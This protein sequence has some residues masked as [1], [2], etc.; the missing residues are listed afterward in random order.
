M[1]PLLGDAFLLVLEET[2]SCYIFCGKNLFVAEY[3]DYRE[4][5]VFFSRV[6]TAPLTRQKQ[7]CHVNLSVLS[8]I[9]LL[10]PHLFLS[11]FLMCVTA[12]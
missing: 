1:D 5:N 10:F 6:T 11:K 7:A 4:R 8:V 2:G 9:I 12:D 3:L